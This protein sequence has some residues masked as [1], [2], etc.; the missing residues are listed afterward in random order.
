MSI[1]YIP[2]LRWQWQHGLPVVDC[3]VSDAEQYGEVRVIFTEPTLPPPR[4]VV[5]K[6]R[7]VLGGYTT[8]DYLVV[9]LG[10]P[11]LGAWS[12]AI[13]ANATGGILRTLH[14]AGKK[15]S[16]YIATVEELWLTEFLQH[17]SYK[18]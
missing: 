7:D 11:L 18:A 2:Q 10:G 17:G 5:T 15:S 6:L 4:D 13:A 16:G 12:A 8:N 9:G 14:W 1:V 3:D